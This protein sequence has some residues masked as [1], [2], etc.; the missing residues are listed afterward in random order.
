MPETPQADTTET[1]EAPHPEGPDR[2]QRFETDVDCLCLM[3]GS[4]DTCF[5]RIANIS[6]SGALVA[7]PRDC[8]IAMGQRLLFVRL[9]DGCV[10]VQDVEKRRALM[11][12]TVVRE[13]RSSDERYLGIKLTLY[14]KNL[15][16]RIVGWVKRS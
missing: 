7:C 3:D 4:R 10:N 13:Y 15:F 1:N 9:D 14:P 12:G 16:K 5:V 8:G 6:S 11:A 2:K